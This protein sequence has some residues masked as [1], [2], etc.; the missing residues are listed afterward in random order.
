MAKET[1]PSHPGP[2]TNFSVAGDQDFKSGVYINS[3]TG[4]LEGVTATPSD[5]N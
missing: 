5:T 1:D 3:L 2:E 4:G